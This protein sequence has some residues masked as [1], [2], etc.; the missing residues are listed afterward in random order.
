MKNAKDF[1][2]ECKKDKN[3]RMSTDTVSD[4]TMIAFAT[5]YA[6]YKL[7]NHGVIGDVSVRA[8]GI[9]SVSS[10]IQSIPMDQAIQQIKSELT[11]RPETSEIKGELIVTFKP[12]S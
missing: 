5:G 12:E 9:K 6:D 4:A 3:F 10:L 2:K 7:K 11:G 8:I 1:L